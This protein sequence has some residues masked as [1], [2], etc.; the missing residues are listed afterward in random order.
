[1]IAGSHC[2]ARPA[3]RGT[4]PASNGLQKLA[5]DGSPKKAILLK[6][7]PSAEQLLKR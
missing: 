7:T 6:A 4:G 1:V 2:R 3:S 5:T